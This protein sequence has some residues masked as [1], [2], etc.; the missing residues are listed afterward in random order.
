MKSIN[1]N[2]HYSAKEVALGGVLTALTVIALFLASILP[3]GR[4]SLYVLSSFFISI[5][6]IESGVKAG[7]IFYVASSIAALLIV[8]SKIDL[9]PYVFF[10]GYYGIAKHYIEK[11]KILWLEYII[12]IM[13]FGI[14][15][16]ASYFIAKTAIGNISLKIS[17]VLI[18]ALVVIVFIVYDFVYTLFTVYYHDKLRKIL[19]LMM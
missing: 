15:A 12:K 8:P 10:F 7:F 11:I 9:V 1:K 16:A 2:N 14:T 3:T 17:V 18:I 6:I 4:I 13:F 5:I 19:K